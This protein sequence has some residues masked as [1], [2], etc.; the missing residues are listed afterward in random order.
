MN[1]GFSWWLIVLGIAIGVAVAW[2]FTVRLPRNDQDVSDDEV[3]D[4]AAWISRTIEADGG[5]APQPLVEEVLLLHRQYL[6]TP[7]IASSPPD[8]EPEP[9]PELATA[10]SA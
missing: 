9:E 5:V 4:E 10:P 8:N 1:D 3:G 7:G 2:L 6:T